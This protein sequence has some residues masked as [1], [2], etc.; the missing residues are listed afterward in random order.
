MQAVP[1]SCCCRVTATPCNVFGCD[2][3][4]AVTCAV[5]CVPGRWAPWHSTTRSCCPGH[6]CGRRGQGSPQ[7]AP[8]H[9]RTLELGRHSFGGGRLALLRL[10]HR[11]R[12]APRLQTHLHQKCFC[13]F[14]LLEM[15][16][17]ISGATLA[18]QVARLAACV[19]AVGVY[20]GLRS[21][22]AVDQLVRIFRKVRGW[23][24]PYTHFRL[25]CTG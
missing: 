9:R 19:A 15:W 25:V 3:V 17:R 11:A 16:W 8:G 21:L 6:W 23:G 7:R 13:C 2:A 20:V 18:W 12:W 1:S 14:L 22:L 24:A 5:T 4:G 10:P